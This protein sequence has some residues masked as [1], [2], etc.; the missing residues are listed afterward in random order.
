MLAPVYR[1]AVIADPRLAGTVIE[2][3]DE[4]GPDSEMCYAF[5]S[6]W[7]SD[8][9]SPHEVHVR[10]GDTAR[11][12]ALFERATEEFPVSYGIIA[13][14]VGLELSALTPELLYAFGFAHELG[15][16]RRM[17]DLGEKAYKKQLRADLRQLP[18]RNT[19]P[20][21]LMDRSSV[22]RR[23]VDKHWEWYSKEYGVQTVEELSILQQHAYR[24]ST[25]ER[26][27]DEFAA[28]VIQIGTDLLG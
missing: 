11:V 16:I 13:S 27:A 12:L 19:T 20:S 3:I 15:H 18:V 1:A 5:P 22:Q 24:N 21:D 10:L 14:R 28:S 9:T 23:Y 8:K 2:P 6:W 7:K 4:G 25:T 17:L 26:E